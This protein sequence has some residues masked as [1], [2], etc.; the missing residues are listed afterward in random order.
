V[1][2]L[3]GGLKGNT[4]VE[5]AKQTMGGQAYVVSFLLSLLGTTTEA[6]HQVESRLL[7]DVV[8]AESAT[9]LELFAGKDEALLIG[10]DAIER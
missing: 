4:E 3:L 1:L 6:E 5:Q 2:D 10:G 7:L 8:I 9:I